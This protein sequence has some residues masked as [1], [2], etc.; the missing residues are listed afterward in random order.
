MATDITID[1]VTRIEGHSRITIELDDAGEVVDAHF[2]VTQFRGFEKLCEGRPFAE[3]PSLMARICGICPVSHLVASAKA[4]DDILAVEPPKTGV[5]LRTLMNLAQIVQSHALSLFYLSSPDLLFGFDA[6]PATRNIVGVAAANPRLATDGIYLRKFGQ[7]TIEILGGKRIHPAWIVPG[8]VES[9]LTLD[10]RDEIRAMIPE[11]YAAVERAIDWYK[12]NVAH[13]AEEAETFGSFDSAFMALV[14]DEG[15]IDHYGGRLRVVDR[16]GALL[17]E[18]EPRDYADYIGEIVDDYSFLKKTYFKPLGPAEGMYR[19]GTLA[20]VI[21]GQRFGTPRADEELADFRAAFGRVPLSSFQY[22]HTRLIEILHGIEAIERLLAEPDILSDRVLSRAQVNRNVGIG[23]AEA[24]RGTLIHHYV[25]DDDGIMQTANLVIATG[26]NAS[27]MNASVLQ[28]ARR[29]V[30]GPQIE[31]GML[32][33]VEAVIR[34]YD[35]CLSCSTHALGQMPLRIEL[36]DA[37]G[38]VLDEV[39]R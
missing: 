34:C 27:A 16:Y 35:P 5:D 22:H 39:A 15:L 2:H 29:Y 3:M 8:G 36:V 18:F 24:P 38:V 26:H 14:G 19:V 12:E 9:P 23:V 4:C 25:V 37:R 30:R 33:R 32:N 28:V 31:E 11:A 6:D 1:P 21:V 20:R 10:K 7:R 17:D 13:W